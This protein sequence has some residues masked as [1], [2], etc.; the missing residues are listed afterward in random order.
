MMQIIADWGSSN[1]RAYLLAEGQVV[2]RERSDLGTKRVL[3]EDLDF[4]EVLRGVIGA[5]GCAE[6]TPVQLSG[7]VGAKNG[8]VDA[9]YLDTPVSPAGLAPALVAASNFPSAKIVPGLRHTAS[10][11]SV[12]LMRGEEVQ[13]FGLLSIAP[14]A[15]TV[16][17]PG[18]HSKWVRVEGGE[19]SSFESYMTGD[20]FASLSEGSIFKEQVGSLEFDEASF[21]DGCELAY[22]GCSL[23]RLFRLRSDYVRGAVSPDGFSSYLSGFLIAN[24]IRAASPSGSVYL[25]GSPQLARSYSI[26]LEKFS[27]DSAEIDLEA[28]TVA[29][30]LAI[31]PSI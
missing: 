15:R 7:M 30:H 13:V 24:E 11:G 10:D 8:W 6:D 27:L 23:D 18:T 9:G 25:C 28:A 16:C 20:L 31:R 22:G 14:D 17:L 2:G 5:L 26:A 1:L 3:S 29:G 19:I 12:D 4:A 21:L